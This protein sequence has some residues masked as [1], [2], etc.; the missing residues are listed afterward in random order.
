MSSRDVFFCPADHVGLAARP[1]FFADYADFAARTVFFADYADLAARPV[2]FAAHASFAAR[3]RYFSF[4]EDM[5]SCMVTKHDVTSMKSIA[6]GPIISP[7]STISIK[8]PLRMGIINA[9]Q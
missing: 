6:R 1:V 2:F 7:L 3:L 8:W 9:V 5:I 4:R